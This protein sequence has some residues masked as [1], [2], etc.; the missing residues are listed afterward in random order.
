MEPTNQPFQVQQSVR[1]IGYD[2][3]RA[4]AILGMIIVNFAVVMGAETNGPIWLQW[5]VGLLEG[6]AAA[7]FVILAGVGLSLLSQ[8]A[9]LAHDVTRLARHRSA[10]WKRAIFLFV[11]GLI[12]TPVWPADI[13][14]FYGV[15]LAIGACLLVVPDRDLWKMALGSTFL[16]VLLLFF[17]NYD[18]GWNWTTLTYRDFWTPRGML[19]HLLFNGFHPVF[20]WIAFLF[21]GM[22]LGRQ[23]LPDSAIRTRLLTVCAGIFIVTES[24]SWLLTRFVKAVVHGSDLADMLALVDSAPIPPMPFYIFSAGSAACIVILFCITLTQHY[25]EARWVRALVATGQLAL[26]LYVAH[27]VVGMGG[28]ELMGRLNNQSLAFAV[29]IAMIFYAAGVAFS[30]VWR[31]HFTRGPL[32]AVM[33]SIT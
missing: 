20:P 15:Y 11:V 29:T 14:H 21:I 8:K 33:R 22:W 5:F 6:R 12:F 4:L 31:K 13:L 18:A 10:L 23:N 3:A 24:L 27:V 7:I 26:T 1:I 16:F 30:V 25:A 32:E 19:R 17:L 28:L 9:R 2:F